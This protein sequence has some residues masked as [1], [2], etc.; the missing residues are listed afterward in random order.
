MLP[1]H[2][3]VILAID[4]AQ[5]VDSFSLDIF[6]FVSKCL[7]VLEPLGKWK[8]ISN[9]LFS[10]PVVEKIAD[11]IHLLESG[12]KGGRRE[13]P[14]LTVHSLVILAINS[15]HFVDSFSLDSLLFVNK[16]FWLLFI[17]FFL[18]SFKLFF[19]CPY[20]NTWLWTSALFSFSYMFLDLHVSNCRF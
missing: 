3:L 11:E 7:W 12:E 4:S 1:V 8:I 13:D 18:W 9:P 6:L 14:K 19:L 5:F 20:A 16:F 17:Y 2:S 10:S 15:A